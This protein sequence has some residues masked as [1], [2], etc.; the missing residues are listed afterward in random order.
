[1]DAPVNSPTCYTIQT[2]IRRV[3]R[4]LVLFS[5]DVAMFAAGLGVVTLRG[6][7]G[8]TS[9]RDQLGG[10]SSRLPHGCAGSVAASEVASPARRPQELRPRGDCLASGPCLPGTSPS[11]PSRVYLDRADPKASPTGR[12]NHRRVRWGEPT[13]NKSIFLTYS[14]G[15]SHKNKNKLKNATYF[16]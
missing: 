12:A 10:G 15:F 6:V 1:M 4:G 16:S 13:S 5:G 9:S 3:N 7:L 11:G 2:C 8:M 14:S